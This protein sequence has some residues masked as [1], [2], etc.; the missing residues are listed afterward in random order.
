[1]L[2]RN[3][4]NRFRQMIFVSRADINRLSFLESV[5]QLATLYIVIDAATHI[6]LVLQDRKAVDM[7]TIIQPRLLNLT[8]SSPLKGAIEVAQGVFAVAK[9]ADDLISHRK[10]NRKLKDEEVHQAREKTRQDKERTVQELAKSVS[11]Q[12]DALVRAHTAD[13]EVICARTT[14]LKKEIDLSRDHIAFYKERLSVLMEGWKFA[15]SV[16]SEGS[17]ELR[18]LKSRLLPALEYLMDDLVGLQLSFDSEN[19]QVLLNNGKEKI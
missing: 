11:S 18:V 5:L 13:F 15:E 16:F 17:E 8:S 2:K 7:Q 14:A 1:V 4:A 6:L 12:T 9:S 19:R 10:A 3:T